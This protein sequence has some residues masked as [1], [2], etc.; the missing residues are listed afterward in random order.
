MTIL[1]RALLRY[2][3][4]ELVETLQSKNQVGPYK[5]WQYLTVQTKVMAVQVRKKQYKQKHMG[6]ENLDYFGNEQTSRSIKEFTNEENNKVIL[7]WVW[8]RD[9]WLLILD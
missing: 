3:I 2:T 8:A 5:N 7:G 1:A 9:K 4:N 6:N